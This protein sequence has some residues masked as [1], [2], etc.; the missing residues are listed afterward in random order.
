MNT[1]AAPAT[2]T[3]LTLRVA[4]ALFEIE[5][6]E[7]GR[8]SRI[9]LWTVC[10][11][12]AVLIAWACVAQL[13]IV[14]VASGRL[15]PQTYVKVVQ[16]AEAGIVREI[17]VEEG[18]RVEEGQV[19]VRLD[20][21]VNAVDSAAVER[22]LALERLQLRRIESELAGAESM[23][24]SATDAPDLF[25]QVDAQRVARRHA[26]RDAT[27]QEGAARDR[28]RSEL[29][30]AGELLE[31][32]DATLPS[33]VQSAEAYEDL[34]KQKLVGELEAIERRREAIEAA[35]DL[36][37]QRAT[38]VSLQAAIAQHDQ[39]LAQLA[40]S[41]ASEL[42]QARLD[43]VAAINRLEQQLGKLQFQQTLLELRAPQAGVVKDLA[44]TTV[45]A[46][47]QPGTVFVTLVPHGEP[48]WAEVSIENKDIG[49]VAVDQP[50]RVKL[51]TYEFQRYGMLEGTVR[52]ISADSADE[53][54][55]VSAETISRPGAP[56]FTALVELGNQQLG[57]NGLRLPL[58]AGM[59]V[60]AEIMQGKRTVL[61]YLLSPVQ[62]VASEAGVE[63]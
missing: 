25:A 37:A 36:E 20:P 32:L 49:F 2:D 46:V 30:A 17:L 1:Q 24:R 4:S 26:F 39:R 11:L 15:V 40:S 31:K 34:A 38:V 62:R 35:Q 29:A 8:T 41:Y 50:V 19:L 21:T 60:S 6:G 9:V 22:E 51:L 44:T 43:A 55:P 56:V 14:A 52:I 27:A 45:G 13:D 59:Q 48:L 28:T 23:D 42:N 12:M 58:A 18:D 53:S 16:P 7:P 57:A 63:R 3:P 33:Y 61:D 54:S 5:M 47:V 10:V